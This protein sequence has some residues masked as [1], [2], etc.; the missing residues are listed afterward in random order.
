[1]FS[2]SCFYLQLQMLAPVVPLKQHTA[3]SFALVE[4]PQGWLVLLH[5]LHHLRAQVHHWL[6]VSDGEDQHMARSQTAFGQREVTLQNKSSSLGSNAFTWS[7]E[8]ASV[9]WIYEQHEL[10]CVPMLMTR[11]FSTWGLARQNQHGPEGWAAHR[12]TNYLCNL[13]KP[14]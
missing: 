8:G 5:L 1:M 12:K 10:T 7:L 13:T 3:L 14:H 9:M 6:V 4:L 11:C 2:W